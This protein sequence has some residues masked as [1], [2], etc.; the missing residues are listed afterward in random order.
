MVEVFVPWRPDGGWRDQLWHASVIYWGKLIPGVKVTTGD[1]VAD[2]PIN[3]AAA[4]NAAARDGFYGSPP[5][6]VAVFA[7]AD[8]MIDQAWQVHAA[9]E[10]A[11]R[12]GRLVYAH[13]WRAGLGRHVTEQILAGDPPQRWLGERDEWDANTFSSCYAVPRGLWEAVGGFDDRFRGWGFEDLAFMLACKALGGVSRVEGVVYHL[14][15]PRPR[16]DQEGQPHYAANEA[17]WRRY[18]AAGTDPDAMRQVLAR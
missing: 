18:M 13:T 2:D 4:R 10:E 3:R 11:G 5:W 12:T 1:R 16:E 8:I 14:W 9:V 17:L 6:Q 15:H 7:D